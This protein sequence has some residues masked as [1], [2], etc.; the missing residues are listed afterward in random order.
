LSAATGPARAPFRLST[1]NSTSSK[2]PHYEQGEIPTDPQAKK[3]IL[4]NA[5]LAN[6]PYSRDE[7]SLPKGFVVGKDLATA[8]RE[9]MGL[10]NAGVERS[11]GTIADPKSGL[12][13]TVLVNPTTQE[14]VLSFGGTSSGKKIGGDVAA[15]AAIGKNFMT[16]MSQWGANLHAGM[17][18]VP[19]SYEQA[20]DLAGKLQ[21][22]MAS[23]PGMENFTVRTVGHSKGGGEAMYAALMQKEPLQAT[24][25]C[26]SHL[27]QGLIN[28]LPE[29]NAAKAKELVQSFSPFGDPVSALRGKAPDVPGVGVGVHFDGIKGSS[30]M[31]IHDQFMQHVLH[32]FG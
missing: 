5:Q 12:L 29:G 28:R 20:G 27:S 14:V 31:H 16:T 6:F 24:T 10:S 1:P 22:R 7:S 8:L 25:F 21:E 30:M 19:R 23:T 2:A 32:A 18:G 13:A 4:H 9:Q 26:P 3:A 11:D 17:G 15:R